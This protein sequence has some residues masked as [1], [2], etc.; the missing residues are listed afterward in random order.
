MDHY[1]L[2]EYRFEER[3]T[4]LMNKGRTREEAE[5]IVKT[6]IDTKERT[7]TNEQ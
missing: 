7:V 3:V 1:Y 6:V 2:P 4:R 5:Q